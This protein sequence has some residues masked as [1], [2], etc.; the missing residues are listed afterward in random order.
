MAAKLKERH[1]GDITEEEIT[2]AE[3][4][5]AF[6]VIRATVIAQ[7]QVAGPIVF[8]SFSRVYFVCFEWLQNAYLKIPQGALHN[9]FKQPSGGALF[10]RN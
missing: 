6:S 8:K 4:D 10:Q 9:V 5:E 1:D 7:Y 2:A 3:E